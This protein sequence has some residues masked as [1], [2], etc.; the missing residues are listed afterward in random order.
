[1][2]NRK[3]NQALW[4]T[5]GKG[6]SLIFD[7]SLSSIGGFSSDPLLSYDDT[8]YASF[9]SNRN[10]SYQSSVGMAIINDNTY[11]SETY[12][13]LAVAINGVDGP[14][15]DQMGKRTIVIHGAN[16]TSQNIESCSIPNSW[17]CL[18]LEKEVAN[19]VI[20]LLKGTGMF[21]YHARMDANENEAEFQEQKE[22]YV[23][24]K[25]RL[26]QRITKTGQNLGW[27]AEKRASTESDLQKELADNVL[28]PI[29]E[30]HD[31]FSH[32]SRFLDS[33]LLSES[34]CLNHLEGRSK[35]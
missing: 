23:Q 3:W 31:Y 35:P 34:N 30:T 32:R 1:V 29:W 26:H 17:G 21:L 18:M 16:F 2:I 9:F 15:N 11:Q 8:N 22:F 28:G 10:D 25:E 24:L 4:T 27:S 6:S 12:H 7:L 33:T 20:P 13:S 14:L 19:D 5:H